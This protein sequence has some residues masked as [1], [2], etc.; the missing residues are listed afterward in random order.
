MVKA[1]GP[2]DSVRSNTKLI[3]VGLNRDMGIS[4]RQ[5]CHESAEVLTAAQRKLWNETVEIAELGKVDFWNIEEVDKE[6]RLAALR[7]AI[8]HMVVGIARQSG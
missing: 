5:E 3:S 4:R 1:S 2:S 8:A 7:L 6:F